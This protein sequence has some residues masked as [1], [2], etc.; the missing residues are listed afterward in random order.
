MQAQVIS[1]IVTGAVSF[2]MLNPGVCYSLFLVMLTQRLFCVLQGTFPHG[3]DILT[4]AD[5]FAVGNL[6]NCYLSIRYSKRGRKWRLL[7]I[8]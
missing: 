3:I 4:A 1:N 5:Y 2:D 7:Q 8:C 6:N